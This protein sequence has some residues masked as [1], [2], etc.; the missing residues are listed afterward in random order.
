[1]INNAETDGNKPPASCERLTLGPPELW[2]TILIT[3]PF[4]KFSSV[5]TTAW[6]APLFV[7]SIDVISGMPLTKTANWDAIVVVA[8][9][10]T[11]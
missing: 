5:S 10:K 7:P 4:F 3:S 11:L 2:L 1:M 8:T 6:P 9:N